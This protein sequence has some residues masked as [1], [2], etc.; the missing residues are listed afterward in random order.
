MLLK[1]FTL[2]LTL[3][4]LLISLFE[5]A[6]ASTWHY[7]NGAYNSS[8]V[9]YFDNDSI[10]KKAGTVTVWLKYVK[11]PNTPDSDGSY[12]TAQRILVSCGNKTYQLL[13]QS[14]YNQSKEFIKS[15]SKPGPVEEPAPDS[16]GEIIVKEVCKP[17]FP[18]LAQEVRDNDIYSATYSYFDYLAQARNDPAPKKANWYI[19]KSANNDTTVYFFD[20]DSVVRVG[21]SITLWVKYVQPVN[22]STKNGD[23]AVAMK[24]TF[25]CDKNQFQS[26][27]YSTYDSKGKFNRGSLEAGK[28]SPV[29]SGTIAD[30]MQRAVCSANFPNQKSSDL[31]WAVPDGDIDEAAKQ[32]FEY[33]KEQKNDPA[34]L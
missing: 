26:L 17:S 21:S 8:Q 20:P 6:S 18:K 31:Y 28:I 23:H 33:S 9:Y 24:Y 13:T 10:I 16:I 22:L 2:R 15:Y 4:L 30:A 7:L 5:V 25:Y 11:E 34:P 29:S 14:I 19:F 27:I 32:L 12:S 1:S 3:F